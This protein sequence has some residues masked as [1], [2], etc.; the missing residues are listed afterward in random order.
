MRISVLLVAGNNKRFIAVAIEAANSVFPGAAVASA[1]SLKEALEMP[2]STGPELLFL[3]DAEVAAIA[4]AAQALDAA[5]LPRWAVVA[6][7]ASDPLPHAEVI[8]DSEWNSVVVS[9]AIRASLALH[10]MHRERERLRGDLLS[11]GIRISHDLRTPV[12]GILS[13]TEVLE[14]SA[15]GGEPVDKSLTRPILE[16]ANDLVKIIGQMALVSKA[17]ARPDS[18]QRFNMATPVGRALERV[19][20][21][22]REK[23]ATISNPTSW[24]DATADSTLVEAVWVGL[25]D[26]AIRH[27]GK[28]PRIELGFEPAGEGHKFWV[29]DHGTGVP[30]AK[31]RSLYHPF[32]RLHEPS[33]PRGLG[34]SIVERLVGFQGGS[35]GFEAGDPVGSTFF[36]T[37]PT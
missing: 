7:G 5:K 6:M 2:P 4:E 9:R 25:L 29:R 30:P 10:V 1:G 37:L 24:P 3:A 22:V 15:P 33:A 17:S 28:A 35:C 20:M 8:P 11:V 13:S 23:G 16:S 19:E 12:G 14:A 32:H 34:L 21:R 36:F 26:N 18:R 31:R 27:S